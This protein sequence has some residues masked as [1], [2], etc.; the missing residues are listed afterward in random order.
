MSSVIL[1]FKMKNADTAIHLHSQFSIKMISSLTYL[2]GAKALKTNHKQFI[3][4]Y[5]SPIKL[6]STCS[7]FFNFLWPFLKSINTHS[8]IFYLIGHKGKKM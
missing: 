4:L 3:S 8:N 6:L 5:T 1:D 2:T 7:F